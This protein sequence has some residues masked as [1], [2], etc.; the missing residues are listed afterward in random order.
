MAAIGPGMILGVLI[1]VPL[2]DLVLF[3]SPLCT[4]WVLI[5]RDLLAA[6]A[7]VDEPVTIPT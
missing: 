7:T 6:N 4:V 1:G 2:L 3:A 5:G